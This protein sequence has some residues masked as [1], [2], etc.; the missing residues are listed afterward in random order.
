MAHPLDYPFLFEDAKNDTWIAISQ[1]NSIRL[2]SFDYLTM[3]ESCAIFR[4]VTGGKVVDVAKLSPTKLELKG[5]TDSKKKKV[6]TL[7]LELQRLLSTAETG[8]YCS[9]PD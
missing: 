2:S 5:S 4:K 6:R 1:L 8:D 7:M 3:V 9:G